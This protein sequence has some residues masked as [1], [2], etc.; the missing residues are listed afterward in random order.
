MSIA[1][2]RRLQEIAQRGEE[3]RQRVSEIMRQSGMLVDTAHQLHFMSEGRSGRYPR[4]GV[5]T[6]LVEEEP[7]RGEIADD[8]ASEPLEGVLGQV[9]Q[10]LV[11]VDSQAGEHWNEDDALILIHL[12]GALAVAERK[13]YGVRDLQL[14]L[15][16]LQPRDMNQ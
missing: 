1:V 14:I 15:E 7:E 4:T 9:Q 5:A 11:D 12:Q 8:A 16:G 6:N 2:A 3:R 10:L 13:G